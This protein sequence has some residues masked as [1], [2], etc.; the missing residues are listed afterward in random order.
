MKILSYKPGHDGHIAYINEGRLEFSIEAEK[1]SWPRY[2]SVSPSLH[3][4][5]LEYV[6]DIPDTISISGWVKGVHSISAPVEGGYFG[7]GLD[8][9]VDRSQTLFG[10]NVNFFSSS[11]ERSHVMCSYGMSP[12]PQGQPCYALVWEGNIGAFYHIDE[13]VQITK[14]GDVLEDPG[15]KYAFL[16]ALADPSFPLL[17]DHHR[18]EDAGKMMALVSYGEAGEV[19]A[20]EQ[21]LIDFVLAQK[22]ILL[23]LNK[24]DLSDSP[25]LNIGVE[26]QKFKNLARK[27]SDALF[28]RFHEF[29][30]EHLT[31]GFPLIISGGC[32]LN[33][34]WNS[35]WKETSLFEDVFIPPCTNDSGSAIGTAVDAMHHYTGKA[36][37]DWS[38]YA[39]EDFV[40]DSTNLDGIH[41]VPLALD[42]VAAFLESGNIIAWVQ[43]RYEIGPRALGNRSLIA[44]PF[45]KEMHA[46]INKI[47][48]REDFRPIAPICLEEEVHKHFNAHGPSPYMLHFQTVKNDK[49]LAITHVDGSARLQSVNEEQ[50]P[51]M[52]ALLTAFSKRTGYG[53]LCNTSLNFKGTGFINRMSDLLQYVLE[54]GLDGIV[55]NDIFY[56]CRNAVAN[57]AR[58]ST[59][60][61]AIKKAG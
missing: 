53:V 38:V 9:I 41:A 55:V 23:S 1:D 46:R 12:F 60:D 39:G 44:A 54:Y 40:M 43:G 28:R 45:T 6:D 22:S 57:Y 42:D 48:Q 35:M 27:F 7:C 24:R 15:N 3:L 58:S 21:E 37:I 30:K 17:S 14:V 33:C 4:R 52:H 26:S 31:E 36:K 11:H 5:C 19:S 51:L 16:Y 2:A 25:F 20:E 61:L 47:K 29:A 49:L 50:N 13:N 18:F 10:K 59:T 34:D 56:D 8:T 32:G